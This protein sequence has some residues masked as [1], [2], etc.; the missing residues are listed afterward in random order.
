MI[1][2]CGGARRDRRG[3]RRGGGLP[4][5]RL[6]QP[7]RLLLKVLG[8]IVGVLLVLFAGLIVLALTALGPFELGR[9]DLMGEVY[10]YDKNKVVPRN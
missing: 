3:C 1:A 5:V 9:D 10:W 4:R 2:W 6:G 7:M 8:G